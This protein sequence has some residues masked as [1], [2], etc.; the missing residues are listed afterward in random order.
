VK[1][2]SQDTHP[3]AEKVLIE[4]LRKAPAWKKL[5]MLSQITTMCRELALSGLRR[6]YPEGDEEEMKKRLAA[7]VLPRQMVIKAYNWDPE[8]EGY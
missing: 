8:K 7:L 6:R 4:L 3:E 2:L 5:K 1:T